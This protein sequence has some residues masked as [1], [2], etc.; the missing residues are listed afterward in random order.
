MNKYL[1]DRQWA[2]YFLPDIKDI[3]IH[4]THHI[5]KVEVANDDQD[6]R[7]ATDMI[8]TVGS[9][10]VAVRI[11]RDG[12]KQKYRDW[13]I[14]SFRRTGNKTELM[15][16][17]EGFCRW[18][19]YCWTENNQIIDWILIDL[20]IVRRSGLLDKKRYQISNW[21]GTYFIAISVKELK[22]NNCLVSDRSTKFQQMRLLG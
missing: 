18:Y 15:K 14:R 8:I 5:I 3:L 7:Q 22:D 20:D 4:N 17:R 16:L 21:D 12:Y 13:T 10:D 19:L 1:T 11:R 6:T 2:D 9:G